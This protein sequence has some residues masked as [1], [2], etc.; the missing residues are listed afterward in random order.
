[1]SLRLGLP[2]YRDGLV[3]PRVAPA[4]KHRVAGVPMAGV[5]HGFDEPVPD[6]S[7]LLAQL[8]MLGR[9]GEE[10]HGP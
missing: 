3:P 7:R 6:N 10:R 8:G 2:V 1:M 9:R 4:L 5:D